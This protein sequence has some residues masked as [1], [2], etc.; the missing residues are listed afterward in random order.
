VPND[1][2][3]PSDAEHKAFLERD[4]KLEEFHQREAHNYY[5][6]FLALTTGTA[7]VLLAALP[8]MFPPA[9]FNS[10]SKVLFMLA[11]A[12]LLLS[13]CSLMI[14][15]FLD[16]EQA[17]DRVS[18]ERARFKKAATSP[19]EHRFRKRDS[20]TVWL[21]RSSLVLYVSGAILGSGVVISQLLSP[22]SSVQAA[23]QATIVPYNNSR[24]THG[25]EKE[26]D[27]QESG[28]EAKGQGQKSN[29]Q[30]SGTEAKG[31]GQKSNSQ[32]SGTEEKV[33]G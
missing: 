4:A 26:G 16:K 25:Q 30:E 6:I 11:I 7:G 24:E 21:E 9:M 5:K 31:Q 14:V 19:F 33:H 1:P 27:S 22:A 18:W 2:L 12:C 17:H 15:V 8:Q 32:E 28:A 23:I 3:Q 20:A 13:A 10:T 29:S